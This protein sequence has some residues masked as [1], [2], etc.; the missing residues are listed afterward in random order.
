MLFKIALALYL[1]LLI[2]QTWGL[3]QV[4]KGGQEEARGEVMRGARSARLGGFVAASAACAT[5]AVGPGVLAFVPDSIRS[6]MF[7]TGGGMPMIALAT[8]LGLTVFTGFLCGLAGLSGKPRPT[9]WIAAFVWLLT[10]MIYGW[11]FFSAPT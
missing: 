7:S 6:W 11:L 5:V 3:F 1:I 2:A 9:G 8:S 10:V 4:L